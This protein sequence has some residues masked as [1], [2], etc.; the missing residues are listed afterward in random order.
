MSPKTDFSCNLWLL[1]DQ[2]G[3]FVYRLLQLLEVSSSTFLGLINIS[4]I[5]WLSGHLTVCFSTIPT[6]DVSHL[7]PFVSQ[8]SGCP[9]AT[10]LRH[11]A[12]SGRQSC[13]C[14]QVQAVKSVG[15]VH[16]CGLLRPALHLLWSGGQRGSWPPG[17]PQPLPHPGSTWQLFVVPQHCAYFLDRLGRSH[18]R[19]RLRFFMGTEF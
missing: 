14:A 11:L 4:S 13:P 17:R 1:C 7:F 12:H 16:G 5:L 3:K 15:S 6:S 18:M 19:V 10:C 8:C 2:H 9:D